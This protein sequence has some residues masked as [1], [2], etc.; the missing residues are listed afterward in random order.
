M[1]TELE[2]NKVA[3]LLENDTILIVSATDLE[4]IHIHQKLKPLNGHNKIIRVFE[5]PNTYYIG[6]FGEY[7]TVHVQCGMGSISP[8]GSAMTVKIALDLLK[9][10]IVIMVGIAFG[11]DDTKQNIGDVLISRSILPYD[12][13]KESSTPIPRGIEAPASQIL[14]NRFKASKLTWEHILP[15]KKRAQLI[16]TRL[17]SGEA[18]IDNLEFRNGLIDIFPESAGGEMEGAGIY[19]ACCNQNTQWIIVKGICDF[20]DGNK[21]QAETRNCH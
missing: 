7:K 14:L 19:A 20:A 3:Y 11:V 5:G 16:P 9:C 18:L 21:A 1:F 13:K 15:D 17:L 2:F 8:D 4:T 10:K 12:I 6:K